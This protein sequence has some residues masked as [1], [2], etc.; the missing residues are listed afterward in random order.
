MPRVSL[1]FFAVAV[2][3]AVVGM[4]WGMEMGTSGDHSLFPAHAHWNLLGWIGMAIY[5]TFYALAR[6]AASPRLAWATFIL[7][8]LGTL[9]L[10]PFLALLLKSGEDLNSPYIPELVA[11]EVLTLLGMICFAVSVWM[12]LLK[13]RK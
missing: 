4:L 2:I 13:T 3:Y 12:G 8:N 10:I 9:I 1:W 5:G 7:A 6:D 11:G